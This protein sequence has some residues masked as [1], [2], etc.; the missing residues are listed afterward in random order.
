MKTLLVS[1]NTLDK[2]YYV[3]PIGLDYVS[4]AISD[5]HTVKLLDLNICSDYNLIIGTLKTFRPDIIG[6][7]LRNV[8]TTDITNAFSFVAAYKDL[9]HILRNNSEALIVI[10]GSAFT[11]F[12]EEFMN[13][14]DVDYGIIG[15]GERFA[16]MLDTIEEGGNPLDIEGIVAKESSGFRL[17]APWPHDFFRNFDPASPHTGFYLKNGGILN[18]QTKRGCGFKCIYCTYPRV[19]GHTLRLV[20]PQQAADMAIRLQEAG[21]KFIFITDA[22]F[23]S[24][25]A[26]SLKIA[27]AFKDAGLNI[28]WGGF[29]APTR[30]P[31]D[32]YKRLADAGLTHVEFGTESL[33]DTTLKA[34][35]KPFDVT[36][37]FQAHKAALKAGLYIMHYFLL[38]GPGENRTTIEETLSNVDKLE[39]SVFFF[40]VGMRIYPGTALYDIALREG[41]ITENQNLLDTVFY[42]SPCIETDEIIDLVHKKSG[43]RTNWVTGAGTDMMHKITSRMYRHGFTGPLWENMI[44]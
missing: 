12:P 17:P 11:I 20:R 7:S 39:K 14:L 36:H 34:Y 28:P 43:K 35:H 29:F 16:L 25:Y 5:K 27:Q 8:D 21:A 23:N 22:A 40:F 3:Y 13:H 10:G 41:Q 1:A 15:E 44:R 31:T 26:H 2:P 6:V 37:V 38:G 32:Y 24:D 42:H 4:A 18:L 9:I 30:A 33:S 19:E